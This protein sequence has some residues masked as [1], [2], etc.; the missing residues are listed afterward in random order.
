MQRW[1]AKCPEGTAK[2][3]DLVLYFTKAT[4][5]DGELLSQLR[6]SCFGTTKMISAQL[7]PEVWKILLG[8]G[9]AGIELG[10]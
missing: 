1:P 10:I 5:N 6:D 2:K 7:T 4:P 8:M 3:M 9:I